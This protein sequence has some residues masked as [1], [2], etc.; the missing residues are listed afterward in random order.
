MRILRV[1][2]VFLSLSAISTAA[3]L[4]GRLVDPSGA[5]IRGATVTIHRNLADHLRQDVKTL[6][7]VHLTTNPDGSF[8]AP[9][10]PVGVFDVLIAADGFAPYCTQVRVENSSDTDLQVKLTLSK[11]IP[12]E[13][14]SAP[15]I[16]P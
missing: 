10:L 3:T 8:R 1:V 14:F 9:A 7:D 12:G 5:T 15:E 2:G 4:K 13:D 6:S 16:K 11:F